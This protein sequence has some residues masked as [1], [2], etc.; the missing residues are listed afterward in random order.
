MFNTDGL[1]RNKNVKIHQGGGGEG[2]KKG[3]FLPDGGDSFFPEICQE[4]VAEADRWG[5]GGVTETRFMATF[6]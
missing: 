2:V 5:G 3:Y 4:K 6:K 1:P